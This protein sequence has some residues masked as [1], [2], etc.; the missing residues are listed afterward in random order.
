MNNQ[1]IFR[2]GWIVIPFVT[3]L[4][5]VWFTWLGVCYLIGRSAKLMAT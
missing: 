5:L 3:I 1:T 2:V 4:Q